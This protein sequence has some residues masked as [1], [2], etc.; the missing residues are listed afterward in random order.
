MLWERGR[1]AA[2]LEIQRR[3]DGPRI[4]GGREVYLD[5]SFV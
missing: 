2:M 4:V 1:E 5:T 3:A